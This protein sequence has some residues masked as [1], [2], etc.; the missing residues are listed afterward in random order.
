[1]LKTKLFTGE[2]IEY[3]EAVTFTQYL[4][5]FDREI[6]YKCLM[7][8]KENLIKG[9]KSIKHNGVN[10]TAVRSKIDFI[11]LIVDYV[12]IKETENGDCLLLVTFDEVDE[13]EYCIGCKLS[14]LEARRYKKYGEN[15]KF[16]FIIGGIL[17]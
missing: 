9:L 4:S 13:Q 1:M 15:R 3:S 5:Q 7:T 17:C 16:D 6:E 12:D 10:D 14:E 2:E 8:N 11:Q